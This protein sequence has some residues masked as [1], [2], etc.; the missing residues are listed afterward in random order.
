MIYFLSQRLFSIEMLS[1][2]HP[3]LNPKICIKDY[4]LISSLSSSLIFKVQIIFE[5]K[6]RGLVKIHSFQLVVDGKNV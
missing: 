1:S 5:G 3:S 2:N 6:K 4:D